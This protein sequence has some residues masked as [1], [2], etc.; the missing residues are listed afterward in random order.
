MLKAV[1]VPLEKGG[2]GNIGLLKKIL[3]GDETGM[4]SQN[5]RLSE[6]TGMKLQNLML[7]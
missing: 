2:F 7:S 1:L 5:L 3:C 6:E 4:K